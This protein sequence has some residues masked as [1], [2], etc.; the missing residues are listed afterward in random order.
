MAV[1]L[2]ESGK[3]VGVVVVEP[4][5]RLGNLRRVPCDACLDAAEP[6]L[7]RG[8]CCFFAGDDAKTRKASLPTNF[9]GP[10][11]LPLGQSHFGTCRAGWNKVRNGCSGAMII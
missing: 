5:G 6:M 1:G 7:F 8:L 11:F 9:F 2:L 3:E 10:F 4:G